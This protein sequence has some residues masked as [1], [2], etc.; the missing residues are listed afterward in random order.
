MVRKP[1]YTSVVP[2]GTLAMEKA[3]HSDAV[4]VPFQNALLCKNAML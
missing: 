3:S 4:V 1:D 2:C